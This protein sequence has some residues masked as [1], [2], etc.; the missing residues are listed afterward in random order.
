MLDARRRGH[1]GGR[2]P[3]AH[4]TSNRLW[5]ATPTCRPPAAAASSRRS[6]SP[7]VA[8]VDLGL[9]RVR[10]R[11]PS[12]ELGVD[13][14]HR[15]VGALDEPDLDRRAAGPWRAVTHVEEPV[16]RRRGCRG[17]TPAA[18]SRPRSGGEAGS[19]RT[20]H[21]GI[22][23]QVEVAV[24]LH[25][26]VDEHRR[27]LGG[28][29]V[30]DDAEPVGDA[31]RARGRRR[32]RRG[33]RRAPRSSPTRSRRPGGS[34]RSAGAVAARAS[35][36]S[37]PRMA[38]PSRLTLRSKPSR[39][40]RRDVAGERRVARRPRCTPRVSA[41]MRRRTRPTTRTRRDAGEPGGGRAAARPGRRAGAP[42]AGRA[43]TR[44]RSCAI[45]RAGSGVRSTSSVS[46]NRSAR[47]PGS[48]SRRPSRRA[49]RRSAPEVRSVAAGEQLGAPSATADGDV[50]RS[51]IRPIEA[52]RRGPG[53]R[54][55]R[56]AAGHAGTRRRVS[57]A[58]CPANGSDRPVRYAA[59]TGMDLATALAFTADHRLGCSSPE[60]DGGRSCPTSPTACPIDGVIR[61]LGDRHPSQDEEPAS[62]R[63][64]VAARHSSEDFW[65]LR[66]HRGRGRAVTGR[67][68]T[69]RRTVEALVEHYRLIAGEH[70]DWDDFRRTMVADRRLVLRLPPTRAYGMLPA[71][72]RRRHTVAHG[73]AGA[74]QVDEVVV[75]EGPAGGVVER[76][77][78]SA[79]S[80][81]SAAGRPRRAGSRTRTGR[82]PARPAR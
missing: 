6:S 51:V 27:V 9:R 56:R 5:L 20:R 44:S 74:H 64:G 39:R 72:P 17:G 18:R 58:A 13:V 40:R 62:R 69:R 29:G 28:R 68:R 36:S 57:L 79:R 35:A 82:P 75:V 77:R 4:A 76:R 24:L 31:R 38:S 26:E 41:R 12:P 33:R 73:E 47:P 16:E 46:A 59:E 2:W 21:E 66:R 19:S 52:Q 48:S 8:G 49:R 23:R 32:A 81:R 1:G 45:A 78:A 7:L 54:G 15:Q 61:D 11:R 70:P 34:M 71:E 67:R 37:S 22:D 14:L 30:V 60:A 3:S 80:A 53:G 10:R 50:G 42:A 43:P 25:V 55:R 65:T 63:P